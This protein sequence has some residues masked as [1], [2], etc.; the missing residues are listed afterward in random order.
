[1]E[2]LRGIAENVR[3]ASSAWVSGGGTHGSSSVTGGTNHICTFQIGKKTV[4]IVSPEP[5]VVEAGDDVIVV[6]RNGRDGIF[7]A[8]HYANLSRGIQ[9]TRGSAAL[10]LGFGVAL[11]AVPLGLGFAFESTTVV[12]FAAVAFLVGFPMCCYEAFAR[13]RTSSAF[14]RMLS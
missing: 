4:R 13:R 3:A 11:V 5:P 6:G 1:M 10:A 12:G 9:T 2:G 14:H 7:H 8:K